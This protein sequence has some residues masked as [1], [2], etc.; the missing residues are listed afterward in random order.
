MLDVVVETRDRRHLEE[1][2]TCLR[3]AGF[4]VDIRRSGGGQG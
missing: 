1:A 4:A 2:V 3:S